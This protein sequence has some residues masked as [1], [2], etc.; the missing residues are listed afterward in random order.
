[1]AMM[2]DKAIKKEFKVEASVNPEKYY[3]VAFL[4][5]KG[6]V[7]KKCSNCG[8]FFWN[9]DSSREFCGDP[10]CAGGFDVVSNNPAKIKLDYVSVWTKFSELFESRGYKPIARYPV[11]ARWNPTTDFV[12]A[13]IAA[14]QPYV[15]TG[16]VEPPAR[17]LVIPQFSLRFG[18][19]D[20][21][22]ITGSHLTGFVMIGQH[23]FVDESE[24]NQ[25]TAFKD[26]FDF[27]TEI[28]G[29][30]TKE[31]AIHE[32]AWAGGGSFGPCMEFFSRGVELFNQV[33]TLFEQTP[34]GN[35]PLKLKVLDMGLGMERIAWF[36]AGAP[37]IYEVTFPK[38]L[39]K[40]RSIT[41]VVPDFD[42]FN[43]FSK[44]SAF[45]NVDE[46]DDIDAAWGNVAEKLN[47]SLEDLHLK[48]KPMTAIY[49][50]AE[51]AR[52]LLVAINDGGLPSN[53]GG[54]YNL[55]AI[56][57]RSLE[58]IEEFDW[59]IKLSDVCSWHAKELQPLFPELSERL[60][61]VIKIVDVETEK[62]KQ[63]KEKARSILQRELQKGLTTEK[64]LELYDSNGITPRMITLEAKSLGVEV[65][66]PKDFYKMVSE[67]H[68]KQ[69]QIHATNKDDSLNVDSSLETEI[70]YFDKW[71]LLEFGAKVIAVIEVGDEKLVV[72]DK[73]AFYPTSGG[74][75]HDLGFLNSSEV[76]DVRKKGTVVLHSVAKSSKFAVGDVVVGKIDRDRR[77]Q[78]AQHHT[79]THILNAA[80]RE[81][82]GDH[83]NQAGAKKTVEKAHLDITHYQSI[84]DDELKQI[85]DLCN[86]IIAKNLVVKKQFFSRNDAEKKFGMRIYQ[87]GA[88]PGKRLRIVEIDG[89]DI[90]AC[91][92]TH[93]DNTSQV[94]GLKILR[95]TK[96]QDGIVRI[97]FV[98]GNAAKKL[99][100][101]VNNLFDDVI[102][103]LGVD[104]KYAASKAEQIF[105]KWKKSKKLV[106]K[107]DFSEMD[108][109]YDLVE[110]DLSD[111]DI[112]VEI[113]K[114]LKTQKEHIV[115][116]LKR[117]LVE[118]ESLK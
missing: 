42:F 71:D 56:L 64:V 88:V 12:M 98:A 97:E 85:E 46:T 107:G 78:L 87:G 7:R 23:M 3:P 69:E 16:E 26:V 96:V 44:Y 40:L 61:S 106:K 67:I 77:L 99:L 30:D 18:D 91:G 24:W 75:L 86:D 28:V 50:I 48:I 36:S 43:R 101:K 29:L 8:T 89:L 104:K 68:E 117:F 4:E 92:G 70:L 112:L 79:G 57:R 35:R 25:E 83:I 110:Q 76:I 62:F 49:S 5:S 118:I 19:V 74:Q 39:E 55:R 41:G 114:I 52:T 37:N 6:F 38:V 22:G 13:S 93:L 66:I 60:N 73:T 34:D 81:V 72:L 95:S 31:L 10:T 15:I 65:D 27:I 94:E 116:T 54:G 113:S 21:V 9:V 14:F 109:N 58:F 51:H 115:S 2:S 103:V 102:S 32:D 82:L 45:L 100:D 17:K 90:E 105:A 33:Y 63:S 11:I 111:E 1:M 84:T 59:N 53:V 80:A 108:W 20:N 47:V